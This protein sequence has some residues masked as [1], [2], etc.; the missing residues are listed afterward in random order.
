MKKILM[1]LAFFA[2]AL[3]GCAGTSDDPEALTTPW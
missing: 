3:V 2:F 1:G